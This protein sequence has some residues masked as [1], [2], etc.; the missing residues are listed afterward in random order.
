MGAFKAVDAIKT[1]AVLGAGNMGQGIAQVFAQA[2]RRVN[3]LDVDGPTLERALLRIRENIATCVEGNLLSP[4]MGDVALTLIRPVVGLAQALREADYVVEAVIEDLPLKKQ[5]FREAD[6][7]CP[8]DVIITS[9]T[10]SFKIADIASHMTHPERA[11]TTH[12]WMP[13]HIIPIVEVVGGD[14]ADP[15][16]VQVCCELLSEVGKKPVLVRKDVPGFVGNRMQ[17]ALVREA[18][19]IVEQGIATAEDVDTVAKLSFGAR[20]PVTG[21]LESM[22]LAG[23]DLLLNIHD[24]LLKDLCRDT[25][26]SPLL[27]K[28]VAEGKLGTKTGQ[29]FRKWTTDEIEGVRRAREADLIA[30]MRDLACN[31]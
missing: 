18:I 7:L 28:L 14:K 29:G 12:F 25:Q 11:V 1:V 13:A 10:S 8:P 30:R 17:H 22:D 27:R 19:S 6:S 31:K 4:E 5:L 20:L 26:P 2:G 24:H 21:P 23:L 3:L 9:N 15:A 16:A